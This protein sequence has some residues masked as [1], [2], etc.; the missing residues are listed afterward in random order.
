VSVVVTVP[1]QAEPWKVSGAAFRLLVA[2]VQDLTSDSEFMVRAA[3]L[4]GLHLGMETPSERQREA[5][6]LARAAQNLRSK[7]LARPSPDEWEMGLADYLPVLEMW[8]EGLVN[9]SD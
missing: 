2:E 9:S 7:L 5:A 3:A 6:L 1:L 8:R 4:N